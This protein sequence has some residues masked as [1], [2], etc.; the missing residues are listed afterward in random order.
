MFSAAEYE[1]LRGR[2]TSKPLSKF[3]TQRPSILRTAFLYSPHVAPCRT[4][5]AGP[6]KLSHPTDSITASRSRKFISGAGN[7]ATCCSEAEWALNL[8][9]NMSEEWQGQASASALIYTCMYIHLDLYLNGSCPVPVVS[10]ALAAPPPCPSCHPK[11]PTTRLKPHFVDTTL[12][13][14]GSHGPARCCLWAAGHHEQHPQTLDLKQ[15]GVSLR[16]TGFSC[17][18]PSNLPAPTSTRPLCPSVRPNLGARSH[19][20]ASICRTRFGSQ[21]GSLQPV[22]L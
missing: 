17:E 15:Y 7:A 9:T 10:G 12:I 5:A 19:A 14:Q 2:Q 13:A 22:S 1:G 8:Y 16:Q 3:T 4:S 21:L 18:E 6:T 11:F 20:A